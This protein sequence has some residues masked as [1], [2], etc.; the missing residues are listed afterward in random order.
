MGINNKNN[1]FLYFLPFLIFLS[2]Y[3]IFY[4]FLQKRDII[5]P[6]LIGKNLTHSLSLLAENNLSL[7]LLREDEN[8]DLP[9]GVILDQIPKPG[10]KMRPNQ[11]LLVVISKKI[12]YSTVPNFV[13]QNQ[14]VVALTI[15][16]MGLQPKFFTIESAQ[17]AGTCIG[18]YPSAGQDLIKDKLLIYVSS[19]SNKL[20]IVPNFKD[21]PVIKLKELAKKHELKVDVYHNNSIDLSNHDCSTCRVIEQRPAAG[22]IVDL[23]K[24]LYLQV[25]VA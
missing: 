15:A 20:S 7:K 25:Q 11:N 14:K 22:S 12:K 10:Q 6:N 23:N 18:Q 21:C 2:G 13:G 5:S 17:P 24:K 3:Y 4:I 8:S 1:I 19:G 9:E 16:K